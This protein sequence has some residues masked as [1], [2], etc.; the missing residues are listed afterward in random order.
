MLDIQKRASNSFM[1]LLSLP[2]TAMG[3]A[4]S[5]QIS[6]LSWLLSTKYGLDIH[7]VGIVWAA[8]PIAGIL[9]QPIVGAISDNVWFWKGRRRPFIWIGGFLAALM[10]L[11]LPNIGIISN[12]LGLD[13]IIGVAITV[14]LTL[15]L[16]I[17]VSFNPTRSLIADVTSTENRTKGYTWMQFISG[18]FGVAAYFIGA[19]LN[20][21][22]LI[23]VGVVLVLL[24]S[25]IPPLFIEEPR[26]LDGG[27][28]QADGPKEKASTMEI[29][30]TLQPLWGFIIFGVYKIIIEL[31]G[32]EVGHYYVELFC[33][34]LTVVMF[35]KVFFQG[36]SAE[37]DKIEF[38]KVMAAHAMT[39][40][41]VQ[42]MFVYTYAYIQNVLPNM[43]DDSTGFTI[44]ISFLILNLVGFLLPVLA[45]EPMTK[46]IGR[47]RTHTICIAIM[48]LSYA[49]I[50]MVG[51]TVG[52]LY[53]LMAF[54]GI[55]WAATV[56]LVFAIMSVRIDQSRMGLYMGIFNLSVVLP[57]LVASLQVG[58][59]VEASADK[60]MIYW[61]CAGSLG[62][63]ALLWIF[64]RESETQLEPAAGGG[65]AH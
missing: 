8:G 49:G 43:T 29:I 13:G 48:A 27:S 25:I 56:S 14:A 54:V 44:D 19:M 12:A 20:K 36:A 37:N 62:I 59:I 64:V 41:G 23:Y 63:S 15:D 60:S 3:F 45:L 11:A 28:D 51:K 52:S 17:N 42:S 24:F 4:L 34:A 33:G 55:G 6:A 39:W 40:L 61:I 65:G 26:E 53:V 58:K 9:G 38:Q 31:G 10:L 47:V 35:G 32:F 21:Y 1:A 16:A 46:R 30:N 7:E 5:I 50:A 57:Q 22:L 2:A 18:F